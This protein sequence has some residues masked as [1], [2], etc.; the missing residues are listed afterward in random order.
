M[1]EKD[2][3]KNSRKTNVKS[4]TSD[5][6]AK[7]KKEQ[8]EQEKILAAKYLIELIRS[9]LEERKPQPK[10]EK[11]SMKQL[12]LTAKNNN[13][14]CMAYDAFRQIAEPEDADIMKKWQ[15]TSQ[16]CT[17]MDVVQRSEG[18]KIFRAFTE[19]GEIRI[20]P[21]KGWIMK[22][23]YP[24]PEY[25][26][27]GDLDFLIDRENRKKARD[28]MCG[29]GYR[30]VKNE[31]D[32]TVDVYKKEPWMYVEIHNH[33]T[34]YKN[35]TKYEK[36]WERCE[37]KDGL[38]AM[39]WDDYYMFML[40]HLEKHFYSS[41]CGVRFLLDLFIFMEKKGKELHRDVLEK[42]FRIRGEENFFEQLE[43]TA[44]SWFGKEYHVG[45]TR[46]EKLILVSGAFGTDSQKYTNRQE[47]IQKK[48]KNKKV[49]KAMYFLTRTFPEYSY[50][51]NIYPFLY[52]APVLMPVMWI[53]RLICA[54]VTKMD[55]I[56]KEVGFWRK[57][58]KKE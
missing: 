9:V 36:I 43:K 27:M 45:D 46:M 33:M 42:E 25:R 13:L 15:K 49:A 32:D 5:I 7:E 21:M 50:M 58:G 18:N 14:I 6:E 20:L 11:V 41:G 56:R 29:M 22:G 3:M 16:S 23:F 52:K 30:F 31:C 34:P 51:C 47:K 24:R 55:R 37:K 2:T 4:N 26:Q 38:Y 40:D 10:P 53:V 35:K 57:M 44:L 28:I 1:N 8:Q 17:V 48:Y 19:Q 54:P 12:F 39:N